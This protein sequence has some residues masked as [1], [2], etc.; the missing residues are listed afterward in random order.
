MSF[1]GS[2]ICRKKSAAKEMMSTTLYWSVSSASTRGEGVPSTG[3]QP[4]P[5]GPEPAEG[6][7]CQMPCLGTGRVELGGAWSFLS[8]INRAEENSPKGVSDVAVPGT[9]G[10]SPPTGG[11]SQKAFQMLLCP[12][13]QAGF[14]HGGHLL[15]LCFQRSL[16]RVTSKNEA[17]TALPRVGSTFDG[18]SLSLKGMCES[19]NPHI[20]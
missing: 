18:F 11:I 20:P 3:G 4:L 8:L 7:H 1:L 17:F 10:W 13:Q 16:Q 14:P 2:F 15:P 9:A 19:P 12:G 5:L 6:A